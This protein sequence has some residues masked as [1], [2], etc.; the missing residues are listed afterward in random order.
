MILE[1][2]VQALLKLLQSGRIIL[3]EIKSA[4]YRTEVEARLT[5]QSDS[6]VQQTGVDGRPYFNTLLEKAF[7]IFGTSK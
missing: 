7:R 1:S 3:S 5:A 6:N 4:E 2:Y